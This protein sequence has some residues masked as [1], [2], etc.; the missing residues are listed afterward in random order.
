L[1]FLAASCSHYRQ[2]RACKQPV[3]EPEELEAELG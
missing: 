1:K 3:T 2:A